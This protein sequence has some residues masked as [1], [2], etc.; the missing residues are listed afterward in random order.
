MDLKIL[1]DD[2]IITRHEICPA[3]LHKVNTE[4]NLTSLKKLGLHNITSPNT[5]PA[6]VKLNSEDR[7]VPFYFP[8]DA[9]FIQNL[10]LKSDILL[11]SRLSSY[12][13][14]IFQKNVKSLVRLIFHQDNV[15]EQ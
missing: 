12:E 9:L 5:A 14:H 6:Y 2:K 13:I 10:F 3:N 7:V 8:S 15:P 4:E 11:S 1:S